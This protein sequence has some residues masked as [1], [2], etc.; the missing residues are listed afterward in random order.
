MNTNA[1]EIMRDIKELRDR[2]NET[3]TENRLNDSQALLQASL[4]VLAA[5]DAERLVAANKTMEPAFMWCKASDDP[6]EWGVYDVDCECEDCVPLYEHPP[7]AQ[8]VPHDEFFKRPNAIDAIR[9]KMKGIIGWREYRNCNEVPIERIE[10]F[11]REA[12]AALDA[13]DAPVKAPS[14]EDI[15]QILLATRSSIEEVIAAL[16]EAEPVK[17]PC[18]DSEEATLLM[19]LL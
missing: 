18:I 11:A 14:R 12:L 6:E 16:D 9:S 13:L 1:I 7:L 19:G 17:V 10:D 15:I 3:S 4:E 8:A 5:L 2:W